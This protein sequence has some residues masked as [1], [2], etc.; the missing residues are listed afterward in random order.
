MVVVF[1]NNPFGAGT[2]AS[3]N[4]YSLLASVNL[5]KDLILSGW[6]GLT[7]AN[8]EGGAGGSADIW[9][10]ALTLAAKDFVARLATLSALWLGFHLKLL[11]AL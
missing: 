9:N 1:A 2:R 3:A 6:G 8:Q 10:Y 11:A 4:H 7:Q 5:S